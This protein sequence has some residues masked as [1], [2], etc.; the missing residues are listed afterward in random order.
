MRDEVNVN[1]SQDIVAGAI[2]QAEIRSGQYIGEVVEF[3]GPRALIKV[4]AV[5]KHP[6]QGDLHNPY[7]P[8]VPMFHERRALS[9]TEKTMVL[10]RDVKLYHGEIP[11]YRLSLQAAADA[12]IAALDRLQRWSE[13]G[14]VL[15]KELRQDYK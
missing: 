1:S 12:Q 13:R 4:L 2:V 6:E 15:M 5:I 7:D 11:D 10:M 14:L 3:N 9:Y 8:D